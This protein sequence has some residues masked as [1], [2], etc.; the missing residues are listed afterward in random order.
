MLKLLQQIIQ[1]VNSASSIY[2]A[3]DIVVER[4]TEELD[5][6]ACSVLLYNETQS[7]FVLMATRGLKADAIGRATVPMGEGLISVVAERG[8]PVKV[9]DYNENPHNYPVYGAGEQSYN[10]FLGVPIQYRRRNLGVLVV[11]DAGDRDYDESEEAF[12]LTLATQLAV[13]IAE[14]EAKG[15]LSFSIDK[16]KYR[17]PESLRGVPSASGVALG[18]AWVVYP[19]A[20][21]SAV[22][23][24]QADDVE[25]ELE[26]F[27]TALEK[28]RNEVKVLARRLSGELSEDEQALFEAYLKM[29]E[30]DSMVAA[31]SDMIRKKGVTAQSAIATVFQEHIRLFKNMDNDYLQERAQDIDDL[32]RR[33]LSNLQEDEE[34]H[35]FEYPDKIVLVGEEISPTQLAEIPPEN[36]VAVVSGSGSVNSHIAILARAMGLPS[37]MGVNE[38]P[39]ARLDGVTMIVDGYLGQVYLD[40][41]E[42]VLEEFKSLAAEEAALEE[43]LEALRGLPTET[44]DGYKVSL[45]VNAGLVA[46]IGRSIT[47]GAEGVGLYRTEVPFLTRDRF[48]SGEEQRVIYRQLL[49]VFAPKPVI[50]RCLDIGGDKSLPYFPIQ[51]DNPFL[52]WRGIRVLL[53]QPEIFLSQL[54]AMLRASE[55]YSNLSIMLPMITDVMEVEEAV[56]LIQKTYRELVEEEGLKIIMPRIGVMAEV[57]SVVYEA[58][59]IARLVDFISVGSNDLTQYIL[60]VDRNNPRVAGLYD[61]LHPAVLKALKQIVEG[62]HEE[63]KLVSICGEMAA[64]PMA[65]L[66]LLGMGFDML[67]VNSPMYTRIKWVVRKFTMTR[68]RK[69][70][71]EVLDMRTA[72]E[73]RRH[74]EFAL[75]EQGLGGLIRAGRH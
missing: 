17:L 61:A 52:G 33:L 44:Q 38:L 12:L 3:L 58:R 72:S 74:L 14:A 75:E 6:A 19:R 37:V 11:E 51:E 29:L 21:L 30:G 9:Q 63:G 68:A 55:G 2:S 20:N 67:S 39:L 27:E 41:G 34:D 18:E 7:E 31:V 45:Y 43:E 42:H 1:E 50:I 23:M 13:V 25:E 64:D 10:I 53:E 5:T 36:I 49:N 4:I 48:P 57:P 16:S 47:V 24:Q 59:N 15:A 70:L 28:T 32:G 71:S 26:L 56:S 73:V 62:V 66:L 22:P 69:I 40:P 35:A 54:R 8:E 60:A 65:T 46:D